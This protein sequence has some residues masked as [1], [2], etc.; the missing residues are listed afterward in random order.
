MYV[1]S[2]PHHPNNYHYIMHTLCV[3]TIKF[4]HKPTKYFKTFSSFFY[5]H[6]KYLVF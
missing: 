1:Q 4:Y 5:M 3:K 2:L 6:V